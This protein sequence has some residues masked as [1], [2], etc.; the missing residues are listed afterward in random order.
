MPSFQPTATKS[1]HVHTPPGREP[2]PFNDTRYHS[3]QYGFLVHRL[4]SALQ[5]DQEFYTAF[6]D[7]MERETSPEL[8]IINTAKEQ[9][10]ERLTPFILRAR[11]H[12]GSTSGDATSEQMEEYLG[13]LAWQSFQSQASGAGELALELA[14]KAAAAHSEEH[15]SS[16]AGKKF[17]LIY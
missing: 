4:V 6:L 2:S 3:V 13:A 9:R 1:I 8:S 15:N 11:Q 10:L 16:A 17:G 7:E 14:V 12:F 5:S